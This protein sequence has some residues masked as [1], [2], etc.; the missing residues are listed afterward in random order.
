MVHTSS[1]HSIRHD[2]VAPQS[3]PDAGRALFVLAFAAL[4][5]GLALPWWTIT[6]TA[7]QYP[8]G[9]HV[10]TG[11]FAVTGD[12]HE[13]D[14]LNH[15]I[16][17]MPLAEIAHVERQLAFVLGPA[18]ALALLVPAFVRGRLASLAALPA[19]TLPAFFVGD[20]AVWL[21]YAGNHL[22]PPA[23]LSSSV[24]PW[25]PV[26]FGQGGVGQF[27]TVSRFGIGFGLAVVAAVLA[28]VAVAKRIRA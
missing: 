17:F 2:T 7:P 13:I 19:I 11:F 16:G 26:L 24:A 14:G 12:W 27:I 1:H 15:Y 10:T 20:L 23:A 25:T 22:D 4:A 8:Y 28:A 18:F 5:I 9:L 3:R 6:M 21:A